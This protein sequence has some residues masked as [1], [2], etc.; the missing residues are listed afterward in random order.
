MGADHH[1]C[2]VGGLPTSATGAT[3]TLIG[4]AAYYVMTA[5]LRG[6]G[7]RRGPRRKGDLPKHRIRQSRV[8]LNPLDKNGFVDKEVFGSIR[9]KTLQQ[10]V[11]LWYLTHN[12]TIGIT[13]PEP[14]FSIS[15]EIQHRR[16]CR[17]DEIVHCLTVE[18]VQGM[19]GCSERTA[20]EYLHALRY[21]TT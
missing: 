17:R 2:M 18:D 5:T 4:T 11:Y 9:N 20:Y 16:G 6:R 12:G 19:L 3:P 14:A 7:M 10:L 8:Q 21:I 13:D 15:K 1:H